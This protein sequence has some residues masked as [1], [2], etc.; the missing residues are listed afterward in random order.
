MSHACRCSP[1]ISTKQNVNIPLIFRIQIEL[2][3]GQNPPDEETKLSM[4]LLLKEISEKLQL[5]ELVL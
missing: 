1:L 5:G 4:K 3:D 2:G